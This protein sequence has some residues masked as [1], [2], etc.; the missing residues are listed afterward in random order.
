MSQ[1][2]RSL[3]SRLCKHVRY[4]NLSTT[5]ARIILTA[6][7][8]VLAP[9]FYRAVTKGSGVFEFFRYA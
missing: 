1:R 8:P 4:R 3:W 5:R 7:F 6:T 2:H 9:L